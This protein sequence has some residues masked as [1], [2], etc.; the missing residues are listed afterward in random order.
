MTKTITQAG[1][2]L[3][4]VSLFAFFLWFAGSN[5]DTIVESIIQ[6]IPITEGA[7]KGL[8]LVLTVMV[9]AP[10]SV[11]LAESI[12]GVESF[13]L[14][15]LFGLAA[16]QL[17]LPYTS[18]P[19]VLWVVV[20]AALAVILLHAGLETSWQN[21]K[22]LW[23]IIVLLSTVGVILTAAGVSAS[24]V[25]IGSL[26]GTTVLQTVAL[27]LGVY[28][29][30]TDP[31]AL[32]ELFKRLKLIDKTA[33]VVVL[34]ESA[35]NDVMGATLSNK[36]TALAAGL[37]PAALASFD[38]WGDGY[39]PVLSFQSLGEIVL[40]M[41]LGAALG[42]VGYF[43]LICLEKFYK[44]REKP[45]GVDS[46]MVKA[47]GIFVFLVGSYYHSGPFLA[48]FVM[49]LLFTT[50]GHTVEGSK[51]QEHAETSK[52]D[53]DVDIMAEAEKSGNDKIDGIL[54]PLVFATLGAIVDLDLLQQY[55]KLSFVIFL[56]FMVVRVAV[57]LGLGYG[58]VRN[59]SKKRAITLARGEEV[60]PVADI[61]IQD[62]IFMALVR[63]TGIVPAVLLV[64]AKAQ[65]IS[66][67]PE[68]IAI[69]MGVILCTL[70]ICPAYK[71]LLAKRLKLV[72]A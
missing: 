3:I 65:G 15:A 48:V 50:T 47:I 35:V 66:G 46:V 70:I 38:M 71:P 14:A 49:G 26:F 59:S 43:I 40:E 9:I 56:A 51:T 4:L 33:G 62:L 22:K 72:E 12:P 57:V 69:G 16:Q 2:A 34:S 64:N 39:G 44:S 10:A 8:I 17:L 6:R 63:E 67:A 61:T 13:V 36:L 24:A 42:V 25:L 68:L 41:G 45:H 54:K 7:A 30:S 58:F 53:A 60:D 55:S 37:S 23:G 18:S 31:A 21:F 19:D 1:M 32:L 52:A 28:L 20:N 27:L 11:Y 5:I 29:A